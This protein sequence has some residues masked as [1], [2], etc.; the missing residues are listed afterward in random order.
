MEAFFSRLS[1]TAESWF[2]LYAYDYS[3]LFRGDLELG[4]LGTA[5]AR[6][7]HQVAG[8]NGPTEVE[9]TEEKR[10]KKK[11]IDPAREMGRGRE[12]RAQNSVR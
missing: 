5:K 4:T 3:L 9:E 11:R 12:R 2:P 8:E 1:E 10:E 6:C 7:E